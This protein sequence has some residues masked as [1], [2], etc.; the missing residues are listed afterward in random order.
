MELT[1]LQEVVVLYIVKK[2][3]L[4]EVMKFLSPTNAPL[5]H[6]YKMLKCRVKMSHEL[7]YI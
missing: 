7:S 6:T 1:Y 4:L 3:K 2:Q 5:Y